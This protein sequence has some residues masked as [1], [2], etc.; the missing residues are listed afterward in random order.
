MQRL[1]HEEAWE[2]EIEWTRPKEYTRLLSKGSEHDEFAN[3]YLISARYGAANAKTIY[4]GKTYTQWVRRRL[5]QPDHKKRFAAWVKNYQRHLFF[6]SFGI[7]TI[8][9][10]NVTRKR[11]DDIERILIYANDPD[12]AHNVQ[13]FYEHGVKEAYQ[14]TN[15]G[16]RCTLPRILALGVFFK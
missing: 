6:V 1:Y 16:S 10:G 3:L 2:V 15:K 14:I 4:I 13:N 8:K 12:H 7:I 5:S 9:E 11:L